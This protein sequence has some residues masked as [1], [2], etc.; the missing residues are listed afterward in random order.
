MMSR[1]SV[2]PM[3]LLAEYPTLAL[4]LLVF[5]PG[6]WVEGVLAVALPWLVIK[7]SL[8]TPWLGVLS[9]LIVVAGIGGTLLAPLA[10]KHFGSR[11]VTLVCAF[12]QA[13]CLGVA[14]ILLQLGFAALAYGVAL[15]AIAVDSVADITFNARTACIARLAREP[16]MRFTSTNWLWSVGG[17]AIGSALAGVLIDGTTLGGSAIVWL[18][19]SSAALSLLVA[20]TLAALM[21][22]DGR[23]AQIQSS[24]QSAELHPRR[25]WNQ[26][27]VLLL[28]LIAGMSFL[29]G[30]VDNL[31]APAHI[32]SNGRGSSAFAALMTAAGVG[33]AA[34]LML[35]R[36]LPASRFGA[37]IYFVGLG[38]IFV[39]LVW[40]WYLPSDLWL[41]LGGFITAAAIAPLLP[42]L[43]SI[44]LKSVTAAQRTT[45]LA[46]IGTVAGLADLA[47]TALFGAMAGE[48]GAANALGVTVILAGL[49]LIFAPWLARKVI[50]PSSAKEPSD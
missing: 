36:N 11:R 1:L 16:L 28:A 4:R 40:L 46:A 2:S 15:V 24:A 50:A 17:M 26:R 23:R 29:Y 21:P 49:G 8:G 18:A 41:V 37:A 33:L 6:A 45:L 10:T 35:T 13:A 31:L 30:P 20:L 25:L 39:Q 22:R 34:G 5:L 42:L 3:K 32:A 27:T 7:A 44:G 43:E 48:V 9:A 19:A 14:A 38:G 12:A 47:G